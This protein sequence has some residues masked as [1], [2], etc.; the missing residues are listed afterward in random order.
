MHFIRLESTSHL[1][2]IITSS[3]V[4]STF[5]SSAEIPIEDSDETNSL[6]YMHSR[7]MSK[8]TFLS[9]NVNF[10]ALTNSVLDN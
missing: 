10:I 7:V 8:I 4:S 2:L 9:Y 3:I 6:K 5:H 1:D